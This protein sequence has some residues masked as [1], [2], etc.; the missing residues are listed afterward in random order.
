[1]NFNRYFCRLLLIFFAVFL[2]SACQESKVYRIGISQCSSDDWREKMNE[3]IRREVIFHDNVSVEIRSADDIKQ[4]QIDDIQYFIDNNFDAIIV[5]P[6]EAEA[7]TPAIRKAHDTGIPVV[8]FDRNTTE[9][10]YTAFQGADNMEIGRQVAKLALSEIGHRLNVLE[11]YGLPGSTPAEERHAGFEKELAGHP[12]ANIVAMGVGNWNYEDSRKVTD[13]LLRIYRNI[14]L[15]YAH[16]DRMAIAA[17][18]VAKEFKLDNI[19]VY[20]ID[21]APEIGIKAVADSVIDATFLY[22]T[23]GEQLLRTAINILEGKP[24]KARNIIP[25]PTPVTLENVE[26]VQMQ[27]ESLQNETSKIKILKG[28]V[29]EYWSRHSSQTTLLYAAITILILFAI[30]IFVLMRAYW[31]RNRHHQILNEQNRQLDEQNRQLEESRDKLNELY[32]QLKVATQSKLVF[33]TNVSHD[34]RTPLTLIADPVEQMTSAENL[35]EKQR[36]LMRLA[37]KNVKILMRLI[38][39]ILDFRK[40]E[41]GKLSLNLAEVDLRQ[42]VSAWADSFKNVA[43]KK[44]IHLSVDMPAETDFRMAVDIEKFERIFFNLLSNAFKFTPEN[45]KINVAFAVADERLTM[46]VSDTGRGMSAE[47]ISHIFDRFYQVDKVNPNGSGIGLALVKAFV[48][49]HGGTITVDSTV[50]VG[51][52]FIVTLPVTHVGEV[53][54]STYQHIPS[55]VITEELTEIEQDEVKVDENTPTV[56]VIDDNADI[57]TLVNGLLCDKYTVIQAAGGAQGIKLASKYIPDLIICDVMMPGIDGMETCRRLKNEVTTSHIPVLMLTA[58]SMDEQRIEGYDAGADGYLSKPFNSRVL[59]ARCEALIINHKRVMD[60][61]AA[62][63]I[64]TVKPAAKAAPKPEGK[65]APSGDIDNEFYNRFITFVEAQIGNSELSVDDMA[66]ELGL[67]RVQFYRKLKAITNY[68]P[69]ELLRVIRLKKADALLKSTEQ[70]VSEISYAVGFSSP[71]Y[72]TKCYRDYFG[73]APTSAQKRT[74]KIQ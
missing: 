18:E 39:Q 49:L 64:T 8:V 53:H 16:N 41:N 71:S 21:A 15:I 46:T 30:L 7:I 25:T 1:M 54:E 2:L 55:E 5:A 47:D 27:N 22:P 35:T 74:S 12:D 24:Y 73:E 29:D 58:C 44:H 14:D 52:T 19:K 63:V 57:R 56:L 45:G 6:I 68:S 11:I 17:A 26:L 10:C 20:G 61:Q 70:T 62:D 43:Y 42:D 40:F 59:V 31:N 3:E 65:A 51:S 23:E 67:S 69:A 33:F 4:K 28:R 32:E 9:E 37:D 36:T 72:F 48:E 60:A 50:D 13:S 34:L 38:N 66:A